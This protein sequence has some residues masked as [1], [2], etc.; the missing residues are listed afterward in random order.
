M[1]EG[2]LQKLLATLTLLAA[3]A[4]MAFGATRRHK[5]WDAKPDE[6]GVE[7]YAKISERQLVEDATFSGTIRKAGK[8]VATYDRTSKDAGKRACP[9]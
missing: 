3:L 4:L 5:V 1:K 8:L 2:R 6:F 7:T 9:T